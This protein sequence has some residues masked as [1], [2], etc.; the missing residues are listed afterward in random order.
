MRQI[1]RVYSLL[2]VYQTYFDTFDHKECW[3]TFVKVSS[4]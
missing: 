2:L 4:K 1:E 3:K